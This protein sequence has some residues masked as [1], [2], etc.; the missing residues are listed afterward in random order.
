MTFVL[1][2]GGHNTGIVSEPGHLH[3]RFQIGTRIPNGAYLDSVSLADTNTIH[4]GFLVAGMGG[5]ACPTLGQ[6]SSTAAAGYA[7]KRIP[8]PSRCAWYVRPAALTE[9]DDA[10]K[11]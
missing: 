5:L 4:R 8:P 10:Q 6:K 3:S 7:R 2:G 11:P 9:S 1:T